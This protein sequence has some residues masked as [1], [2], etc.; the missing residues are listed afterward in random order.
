MFCMFISHICFVLKFYKGIILSY[1]FLGKT[2]QLFIILQSR[3]IWKGENI[4]SYS[5]EQTGYECQLCRV[6][7]DQ[8]P[9]ALPDYLVPTSLLPFNSQDTDPNRIQAPNTKDFDSTYD[10]NSEHFFYYVYIT[11]I[12]PIGRC[13]LSCLYALLMGVILSI[14]VW[15]KIK[16]R[17]SH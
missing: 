9:N 15:N 10:A 6:V 3:T 13:S 16:H 5:R 7:P 1:T 2:I 8:M 12:M 4:T 11:V 14:V 17:F